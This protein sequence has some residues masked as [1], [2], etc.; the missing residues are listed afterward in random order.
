[1]NYGPSHPKRCQVHSPSLS[2][3]QSTPFAKYIAESVMG[4]GEGEGMAVVRMP[5]GYWDKDGIGNDESGRG[6]SW[7]AG[8]NLGDMVVTNAIKQLVSGVGGIYEFLMMT[9]P[10]I[11]VAK[12]RDMADRYRTER[13]RESKGKLDELDR[14]SE[15]DKFDD[16]A[17]HF[18]R[19]MG[20]TMP[21]AVYGA[22]LPGS[23]FGDSDAS[24]WNVDRLD[25]CLQLLSA[26]RTEEDGSMPGVTSSY[27]YFGM[28]AACFAAH[29]EDMNLLSINILHAGDPKY[30]YAVD[31][32]DSARFESL[33]QS[34]FPS[35]AA[36]CQDFMRHKR[37]VVSPA[38]LKKAGISYTTAV[39]RPGDAMITFPG[40]YH[41]GF[42]TGFNVAE[43]TNFAVR[44][45]LPEGRRAT[46]C[47]CHPHS[48]RINICR[49][50][51]L[52]NEYERDGGKGSY[53]E[54]ARSYSQRMKSPLS[55][56]DDSS[57]SQSSEV[58]RHG[59][60][61][62]PWKQ[63]GHNIVLVAR[64]IAQ[65]QRKK[66]KGRNM[67]CWHRA[68]VAGKH[69]YRA[70]V[71]VLCL[72]EAVDLDLGGF[73]KEEDPIIHLPP[74]GGAGVIW[75]SGT[76]K[77]IADGHARVHFEGQN[78]EE[79]IWAEIGGQDMMIDLGSQKEKQTKRK[80]DKPE[81]PAAADRNKKKIS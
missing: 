5:A 62:G 28:Y 60:T 74:I 57:A 76:I 19:S 65:K 80:R 10:E 12:F 75:F 9:R 1:M 24:G 63:L 16:M 3:I 50:T 7:E 11:T 39:Q 72:L 41:F 22:D 37:F 2:T 40:C 38:I 14:F 51:A 79:D 46:V 48:V 17:R 61:R 4:S 27:L 33:L 47:M 66:S 43:S 25:T 20:P 42:N 18:W 64:T 67:Y 70:G 26:D 34:Y 45:W 55:N 52:L 23:L 53:M 6:K 68:F 71:K 29:T 35:D 8:T 32:A 78:K 44:E 31:K 13:L 54:W 15:D 73:I 69:R 81:K 77:S 49:F 56:S 30:W 59:V 58:G 21:P 36:K